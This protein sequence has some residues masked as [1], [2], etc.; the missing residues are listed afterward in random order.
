[1]TVESLGP[2]TLYMI[3]VVAFI[4]ALNV[5]GRARAWIAA[6]L[7]AVC[8]G[9]AL[10]YTNA[11]RARKLAGFAPGPIATS[12]HMESVRGGGGAPASGSVAV[13]SPSSQGS[14]PAGAGGSVDL[15]EDYM[16]EVAGLAARALVLRASLAAEDPGRARALSDSAYKAFETRAGDYLSRARRLRER[17][18]Q[19]GAGPV[20]ASGRTGADTAAEEAVEALNEA[21]QPL[22]GAA[23][24]L[25]AFFRA[26]GRDEE[27]RLVSAYRR[28]VEAAAAPLRRAAA[29]V[30][31][32]FAATGD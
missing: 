26:T 6:L 27:Q 28:G 10:W 11:W 14:R 15:R 23:R 7:V 31:A 17:A 13:A 5:R 3:T 32:D 22:A 12:G 2:T 4:G 18:A 21:L 30:G 8:L 20:S 25:R 1:M 29:G 9:A 16:T 24:D 19:L